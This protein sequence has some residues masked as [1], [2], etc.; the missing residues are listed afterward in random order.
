MTKGFEIVEIGVEGGVNLGS[1]FKD[2][3]L[4]NVVI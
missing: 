4:P 1:G 2:P 3:L